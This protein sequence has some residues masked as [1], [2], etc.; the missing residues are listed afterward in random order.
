[1]LRRGVSFFLLNECGAWHRLCVMPLFLAVGVQAKL[2][3]LGYISKHQAFKML[4]CVIVWPL[5]TVLWGVVGDWPD[6]GAQKKLRSTFWWKQPLSFFTVVQC[7]DYLAGASAALSA[8]ASALSALAVESLTVLSAGA[9]TESLSATTVVSTALSVAAAFLS[10]LPQEKSDTL[11]TTAS[12]KTN[13]FISVIFLN[14]KTIIFFFKI[15][16]NL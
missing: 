2:M 15:D 12:N 1:M 3:Q 11:N 14:N 13:F 5:M 9:T 6:C 4:R 7:S 16:A 8:G 10:A